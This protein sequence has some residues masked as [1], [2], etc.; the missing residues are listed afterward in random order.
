MGDYPWLSGVFMWHGAMVFFAR[1]HRF[2]RVVSCV[3]KFQK[4]SGQIF[5]A[6]IERRTA[7]RVSASGAKPLTP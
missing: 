3:S 2:I 6:F 5:A 7:K 1:Q 4:K